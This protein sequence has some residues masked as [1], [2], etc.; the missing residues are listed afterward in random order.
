MQPAKQ[1]Q[2]LKASYIREILQAA[3][4]PDIISLAG[5]LPAPTMLPL[6]LIDKAIERLKDQPQLFQYGASRGLSALIEHLIG[7]YQLTGPE[8]ILITNGS[9]QGLD[10]IA[11]TFINPGDGVVLETPAYPGALQVFGLAQADIHCIKQLSSGP[12][13]QMLEHAFAHNDIKLFYCVPDFHNPTGVAWSDSTRQEVALLCRKYNVALVDDSPYR[14]LRF[15]GEQLPMMAHY[16]PEGTLVL[17]SFSKIAFPGI[18]L[19]SIT[20]PEQW[21]T[22]TL[23]VKQACDL[24]TA[25]PMQAV[26]LDLFSQHKFEDHLTQLRALY[27]KHY[28]ALSVALQKNL[29]GKSHFNPVSGGM[30]LWLEIPGHDAQQVASKALESGVAVV[31]SDAFYPNQN[32]HTSALRLNF[33][34]SKRSQLRTAVYRLSGVL[35]SL[36]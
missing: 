25:L 22:A 24:H 30:F 12:D 20:G 29:G 32:Y 10:L 6:P 2:T 11:R 17:R 4:C 8:Q 27:S 9:Q 3:S 13:L 33:S 18:R 28:Q 34:N 23:K 1:T 7:H 21:I 35:E 31:P 16:Y 14:E 5:G 36:V 26:A 19:G 15:S